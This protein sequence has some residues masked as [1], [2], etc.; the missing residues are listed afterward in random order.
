MEHN[1]HKHSV[2]V[3]APSKVEDGPNATVA[4]S[5]ECFSKQF[6]EGDDVAEQVAILEAFRRMPLDLVELVCEHVV[7]H[8]QVPPGISLSGLRRLVDCPYVRDIDLMRETLR[9]ARG[10]GLEIMRGDIA[11]RNGAISA[12]GESLIIRRYN[13]RPFTRVAGILV[14]GA[15][16]LL[17][18]MVITGCA[19]GEDHRSYAVLVH[20]AANCVV[21][22][23]SVRGNGWNG[24]WAFGEEATL[25]IVDS[26]I[27]GCPG[28]GVGA[29]DGATVQAQDTVVSRCRY[30]AIEAVQR[31]T[32]F[33]FTRGACMDSHIGVNAFA[34]ASIMLDDVLVTGNRHVGVRAVQPGTA[35][36]VDGC[37]V[38]RN[39]LYALK[40]D[41]SGHITVRGGTKVGPHQ[42]Q[43]F[44]AGGGIVHIPLGPDGT[45][46]S[47]FRWDDS[48]L[49]MPVQRGAFARDV[50]VREGGPHPQAARAGVP[51]RRMLSPSF[52][53]ESIRWQTMPFIP[54]TPALEQMGTPAEPPRPTGEDPITMLQHGASRGIS[55]EAQDDIIIVDNVGSD[56]LMMRAS[57][58]LPSS[59]PA[60]ELLRA[61]ATRAPPSRPSTRVTEDLPALL[62]RGEVG[63]T[64][65]SAQP[66]PGVAHRMGALDAG[67]SSSGAER[68]GFR[69]A[70]Q[71]GGGRS[72]NEGVLAAE[73]AGA[74]GS[75]LPV[76]LPG[77]GRNARGPTDHT[78]GESS[79]SVL[80]PRRGDTPDGRAGGSSL[81]T[82]AVDLCST[83]AGPLYRS[84]GA[85]N[86]IEHVGVRERAGPSSQSE[87][88]ASHVGAMDSVFCGESL[89]S[90]TTADRASRRRLAPQ[91]WAAGTREKSAVA[92]KLVQARQRGWPRAGWSPPMVSLTESCGASDVG[93]GVEATVRE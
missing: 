6:P 4:A 36:S 11:I 57:V 89:A 65:A 23:C 63:V 37:V 54:A 17:E 25:G 39:A 34:G 9:G 59:L 41:D 3:L 53:A 50:P 15:N 49:P 18:D 78:I 22:R 48:E 88:R 12:P 70:T 30:Q 10:E 21:R 73:R 90:A 76:P 71:L 61:R 47:D 16:V 35:V 80:R 86:T 55:I 82:D 33:T 8:V 77:I 84:E 31:N 87:V 91:G 92:E 81:P 45:L 28:S 7:A 75:A 66:S 58:A 2:A 20:Q 44:N 32:V 46:E 43:V 68:R 42:N 56:T 83:A 79:A 74:S 72:A 24:I 40:A 14:K 19:G 62:E 27:T 26:C 67:P 13:G 69:L 93:S 5:A 1:E 64:Q 38:A 52:P 29:W 85:A 51:L 60:P